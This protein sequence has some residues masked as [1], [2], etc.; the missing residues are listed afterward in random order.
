MASGVQFVETAS[1][2]ICLFRNFAVVF[3]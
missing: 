1:Q 2:T 3:F